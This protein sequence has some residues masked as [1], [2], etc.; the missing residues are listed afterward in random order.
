[1]TA[2]TPYKVLFLCTHNSSRSILAEGIANNHTSGRFEAYSA[3]S[4]PSTS[5]NPFALALLPENHIAVDGVRSKNWDEFAVPGAP[6][7]D[8]IFTV[9]D[10][11][12][13]E[14]CPMWPGHPSKAHWGIPDPSAVH[15]SDD[16]KRKAFLTAFLQLR[17]RIDLLASLPLDTL[18]QLA[19]KEQIQNIGTTLRERG[20]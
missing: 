10:D 18:D 3:G 5:P 2:K 17:K 13:G 12:A 19:L 15:G 20:E 7:F 14:M 8:F 9:C 1:M 16:V 11:A 4:T 6:K